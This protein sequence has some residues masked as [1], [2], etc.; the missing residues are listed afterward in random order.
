MILQRSHSAP[1][2]QAEI[3]N[4]VPANRESALDEL[5]SSERVYTRS[6]LA[7][8][9]IFHTP[10]LIRSLKTEHQLMAANDIS[11]VFRN[12]RQLAALHQNLLKGVEDK[13]KR[14][15]AGQTL[16]DIFAQWSE[17][18][19]AAY[20]EFCSSQ[21]KALRR[22]GRRSASDTRL[23]MFL[24]HAVSHPQCQG[25]SLRSLLILPSQRLSRYI[26][27]VSRLIDATPVGHPDYRQLH[28]VLIICTTAMENI[29]EHLLQV[30]A[31]NQWSRL[32]KQ[33]KGP[34]VERLSRMV[35]SSETGADRPRNWLI[36]HSQLHSTSDA[37]PSQ[38]LFL[39][40][41]SV[42]LCEGDFH[43]GFHV[44]QIMAVDRLT[45]LEALRPDDRHNTISM[46]RIDSDSHLCVIVPDNH[47]YWI[48]MLSMCISG[49]DTEE[50]DRLGSMVCR[51]CDSR[52]SLDVRRIPC[53]YCAYFVCSSCLRS[54]AD[55]RLAC[56]S[57]DA[58][59]DLCRSCSSEMKPALLRTTSN[60]CSVDEGDRHR[61]DSNPVK[62]HLPTLTIDDGREDGETTVV[63]T[64]SCGSSVAGH[65]TTMARFFD[66]ESE[67]IDIFSKLIALY[68]HPLL[69][70]S[71]DTSLSI[72]SR[73]KIHMAFG[74]S[75]ALLAFHSSLLRE[76][77][78]SAAG[79]FESVLR[80][81]LAQLKVYRG[82][83][84][85]ANVESALSVIESAV[86]R[87]AKLRRFFNACLPQSP[88]ARA[89][90]LCDLLEMPA[91]RLSVYVSLL[92][93]D[94]LT[95]SS[96]VSLLTSI[97]LSFDRS[98]VMR[99]TRLAA[100]QVRK[101]GD[102]STAGQFIR[103][104]P[105]R[106]KKEKHANICFLFTKVMII[107]H[108]N[109]TSGKYNIIKRM[110]I[111]NDVIFVNDFIASVATV[112]RNPSQLTPIQL[113]RTRKSIILHAQND[114]DRLAWVAALRRCLGSPDPVECNISSVCICCSKSFT[115]ALRR[116]IC[117]NCCEFI[118][119]NCANIQRD[120][121]DVVCNLCILDR[122]L[123]K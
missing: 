119:Q 12:V 100:D 39:F 54:H 16:G 7:I 13:A 31:A 91:Q 116:R 123:N 95:R 111:G 64:P 69:T 53:G 60:P 5:L 75:L 106:G 98:D 18:M 97:V 49:S 94:S 17:D 6:L 20:M 88:G 122:T 24:A 90:T 48:S 61:G 33:L 107:C 34:L 84:F 44:I 65:S 22:L 67:F 114:R 47:E 38:H 68:V 92:P 14:W 112:A 57:N 72:M 81:N 8:R 11:T 29:A 82:D 36:L 50:I 79:D 86:K 105:L 21:E 3:P 101:L 28:D 108:P 118:C 46:R 4:H 120:I 89:V 71:S 62:V 51:C 87:E 102:P 73:D 15:S 27:I 117:C 76:F 63:N 42:A 40:R 10:L 45:F 115:I 104:G 70:M 85:V 19:P 30:S 80:N 78:N 37:L 9:D 56:G 121:F 26:Q 59:I 99:R 113:V 35:F 32:R 83:A 93:S 66:G 77:Q 2:L 41:N 55:S 103:K 58:L 96:L 25:D 43:S 23:R 109:K 1:I 110:L 52:F 74:N